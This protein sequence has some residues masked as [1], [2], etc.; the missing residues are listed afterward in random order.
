[1]PTLTGVLIAAGNSSVK[2]AAACFA[3]L[4]AA[5]I[6]L[7][8]RWLGTPASLGARLARVIAFPVACTVHGTGGITGAA[9]L[10]AGGSGVGKTE[11]GPQS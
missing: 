11:R 7:V 8:E 2:A 6:A 9:H 10:M 5:Q 4:C 1:V 3:A